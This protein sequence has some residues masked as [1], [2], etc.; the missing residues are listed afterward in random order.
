MKFFR[1]NLDIDFANKYW[2][3]PNFD[4]GI[5][6][7][8]ARITKNVGTTNIHIYIQLDLYWFWYTMLS[9]DIPSSPR[10]TTITKSNYR[11]LSRDINFFLS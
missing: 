7:F 8:K 11:K 3:W 9:D 6:R 2:L 10:D 4:L 5:Y 1:I